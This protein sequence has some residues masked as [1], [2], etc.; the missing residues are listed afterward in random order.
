MSGLA[1]V[2][3]GTGLQGSREGGEGVSH[4]APSPPHPGQVQRWLRLAHVL[5]GALRPVE[6]FRS[7]KGRKVELRLG[8]TAAP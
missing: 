2:L 3:Q 5:D 8:D 7:K 4:G 6:T 1:G